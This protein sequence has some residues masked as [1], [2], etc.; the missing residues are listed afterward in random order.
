MNGTQTKI[1]GNARLLG[2]TQLPQRETKTDQQNCEENQ[3]IENAVAN[4]FFK[5]IFGQNPNRLSS[6]TSP[7]SHAHKDFFERR[8]ACGALR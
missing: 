6:V 3:R 8:R 1:G 5:S 2:E 4:H 7:Q